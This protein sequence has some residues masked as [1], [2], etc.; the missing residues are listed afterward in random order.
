[1]ENVL[2]KS[3][4]SWTYFAVP[5]FQDLD[6]VPWQRSKQKSKLSTVLS[7]PEVSDNDKSKMKTLTKMQTVPSKSSMAVPNKL[8]NAREP[9]KS[10]KVDSGM[11]QAQIRLMKMLVK[12]RKTL[13]QELRNHETFLTKLNLDLIS[14]IQDMEDS[15]ALNVRAML[16]Q[17]DILTTIVDILETSN[18]KR[19]QQLKSE[20]QELE[21]KEESK[22]KGLEQQ[23]K[24]LDAKI[25][26]THE[27]VSF[28]STY[29]D[30][31]YPVKSVQITNLVR[32][33][34]Q[35]KDSHQEE[36]DDLSELRKRVLKSLSDKMQ[37]KK[38]NILKSLV[39]KTQ[40]P[41]QEALL[42]KTQD[43]QAILKC[44]DRFKKFINQFEEEIPILRA[45]VEELQNKTLE[46]REIIFE[47]VLLR[48]PKCTPDMDVILN[49][50]V[51]EVLPF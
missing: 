6:Y 20:L 14:T 51:E 25:K 36:L 11:M 7:V 40:S 24:Q 35:V 18:N 30:H 1:M 34:Q 23:V 16:Q 13:L 44:M 21:E 46:P 27:E 43:S 8:K 29:M 15:T 3:A 28:L 12:N 9:R 37:N 10:E 31:E 5:K 2:Q 48:R 17:Q 19:L 45:E 38:I 26:K 4:R 49:I 47:D 42:Q 32:Q 22:M 41:Y 39:V 50:P 33:L